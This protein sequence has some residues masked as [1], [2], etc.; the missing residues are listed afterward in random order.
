MGIRSSSSTL[1][2]MITIL[3]LMTVFC[4]K[5][6][7]AAPEEDHGQSEVSSKTDRTVSALLP[8]PKDFAAYDDGLNITLQFTGINPG[9]YNSDAEINGLDVFPLASRFNEESNFNGHTQTRDGNDCIDGNRDGVLNGLDLFII[10]ANFLSQLGGYQINAQF[11]PAEPWEKLTADAIEYIPCWGTGEYVHEEVWNLP[12]SYTVQAINLN[13]DQLGSESEIVTVTDEDPP[14][15]PDG[16]GIQW[17]VHDED[18]AT[19]YFNRA[20][21]RNGPIDY[22]LYMDSQYPIRFDGGAT[23][24]NI[25]D[26]SASASKYEREYEVT[27]LDYD[28]DHYLALRAIDANDPPNEDDNEVSYNAH[29]HDRPALPTGFTVTDGDNQITLDWDPNQE[30]D[31]AGYRIM[32]CPEPFPPQTWDWIVIDPITDNHYVDTDVQNTAFRNYRV[33]AIDE[34]GVMSYGG[35]IAGGWARPEATWEYETADD[36]GDVFLPHL[37]FTL[38][39]DDIPWFC[40]LDSD[41]YN[42]AV[43]DRL[44]GTWNTTLVDERDTAGINCFITPGQGTEVLLAYGVQDQSVD[45]LELATWNGTDWSIEEIR[46]PWSG[47][48][49]LTVVVDADGTIW[50]AY[51]EDLSGDKYLNISRKSGD[52]WEHTAFYDDEAS[53]PQLVPDRDDAISIFF[54]WKHYPYPVLGRLEL[55]E[56]QLESIE[57]DRQIQQ[58]N[59]DQDGEPAFTSWQIG[60]SKF[61]LSEFVDGNWQ[62]EEVRHSSQAQPV[63]LVYDPDNDPLVLVHDADN[64]AVLLFQRNGDEWTGT[65][66]DGDPDENRVLTVRSIHLDSTGFPHV[67]Y[68]MQ[69]GRKLKY[70]Y[71]SQDP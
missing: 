12:V 19:I 40:Y 44:A 64:R 33:F 56:W 23:V 14:T 2:A 16:T 61:A 49:G 42:L 26:G 18:S 37:R 63:G 20:A 5:R 13:P 17:A 34:Y 60:F 6:D 30:S 43:A 1:I 66:I 15:W 55:G 47:T 52:T 59:Y 69:T 51:L 9:D 57:S 3:S 58:G 22:L 62:T 67:G 68:I 71:L 46:N 53:N 25:D 70:A 31:L 50:C 32:R 4:G 11:D 45:S 48:N 27:G 7:V 10:A 38:D 28:I 8:A 54:N 29:T 39:N 41:G 35:P 65:P 24:T 36:K 21:D